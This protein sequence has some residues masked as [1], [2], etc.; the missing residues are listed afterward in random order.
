ML[1]PGRKTEY[2]RARH[3]VRLLALDAR[4]LELKSRTFHN[5]TSLRYPGACRASAVAGAQARNR[6]LLHVHRK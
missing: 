3:S 2:D 4:R 1:S 6:A 5:R